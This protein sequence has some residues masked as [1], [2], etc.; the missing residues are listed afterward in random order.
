MIAIIGGGISGASLA[1]FL[2]EAG[3]QVA[4]YEHADRLGGVGAWIQLGDTPV[5]SFYHVL[6]G[7]KTPLR[8]LIRDVGLEH[9]LFPVSLTQGFFRDGKIYPA[10]SVQELLTFQALDL[11]DRM[12]LGL[13]IVQAVLTRDWRSLDKQTA[14]EWLVKVGGQTLYEQFWRPIMT[15]RFGPAVERVSAADMWYRIHRIGTVTL[16]REDGGSCYV[17]GTLRAL[18]EALATKLKSMGVQIH[19]NTPVHRLNIDGKRLH[20]IEIGEGETVEADQVIAAAPVG[21]LDRL[22]PEELTQFRAELSRI[23]YLC[24]VCLVLK[25]SRPISPYYQ[26]N[27]GNTGIPFTGVI[28]ADCLYPPGEYGGYITYVPRY[29]QGRDE[30][31]QASA[32]DLLEQYE[33][34][35][36]QICPDFRADWIKDMAVSRTRYADHLHVVGY[37][38]LIPPYQTPIQGLYLLS[39]AQI[40]PEP[41]VLD[42]AVSNAFKLA[43]YLCANV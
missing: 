38:D 14:R 33:P 12:R 3:E 11:A 16:N 26:L 8:E 28:A 4:L 25:T 13:T 10:S 27:L 18:F 2:A 37:A 15:C 35:L 21:V 22:L 40:Y 6:T 39:M 34:Y 31:F 41:T 17:K 9:A 23:E 43:D 24:N 5:D 29:F 1:Y 19:L 7:G 20:S 32:R 36:T 30:L 42:T